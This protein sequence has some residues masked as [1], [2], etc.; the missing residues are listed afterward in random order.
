MHFLQRDGGALGLDQQGLPFFLAL[1]SPA[2]LVNVDSPCPRRVG[3]VSQRRKL[4]QIAL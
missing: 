3:L 1:D 4:K 2:R